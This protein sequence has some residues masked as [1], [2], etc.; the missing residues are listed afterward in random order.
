MD[1]RGRTGILLL[2]LVS[3][4]FASPIEWNIFGISFATILPVTV[5]LV[6]LMLSLAWMASDAFSLPQLKGWVKIELRE[7][8]IGAVWIIIAYSL[9]FGQDTIVNLLT[10]DD[11]PSQTA[12][13]KI[14]TH[15]DRFYGAY[16][17]TLKGSYYLG[18]LSGY[19]YFWPFSFYYGSYNHVSTPH[20]GVRPFQSTFSKGA[21]GLTQGIFIYKGLEALLKFLQAVIPSV[22]L[23]FALALRILPFTRKA[24]STLLAL[25]IGGYMLLPMSTVFIFD[26]HDSIE[27]GEPPE[28][29][30][31][32]LKL[33]I[34]LNLDEVCSTDV[35]D[36]LETMINPFEAVQPKNLIGAGMGILKMGEL[37]FSMVVCAITSPFPPMA[38]AACVF[39]ESNVIYN[40][41]MSIYELTFSWNFVL[42]D[43]F[44]DLDMGQ[45]YGEIKP[46]FQYINNLLVLTYVDL[47]AVSII[48]YVGTKSISGAVGGEAFLS[49]LRRLI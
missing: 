22:A 19:G 10:G 24:G 35:G 30:V 32:N 28:I 39:Y 33:N 48:T 11:N 47:L 26:I 31:S 6:V 29:P 16:D 12:I 42:Q 34:P 5:L 7:L 45:I 38:Y 9:F 43:A 36:I 23:P 14:E 8:I 21:Q 25:C 1:M 37:P 15:L 20:M 49:G 3:L 17:E 46:L 41:I 4:A 27:I 40:L 13:N 18:L 2:L 44:T